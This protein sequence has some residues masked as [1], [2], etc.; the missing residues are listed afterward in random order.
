MTCP[1]E[2]G[3]N[4]P[5]TSVLASALGFCRSGFP[6]RCRH[7]L[8]FLSFG[9]RSCALAGPTCSVRLG[10]NS[11]VPSLVPLGCHWKRS[12]RFA[13]LRALCSP[14]RVAPSWEG[15]T[16]A[17]SDLDGCAPC[18][19]RQHAHFAGAHPW[20]RGVCSSSAAL[21]PSRRRHL[22]CVCVRVY[23]P[24]GGDGGAP[25]LRSATVPTSVLAA[26]FNP[27]ARAERPGNAETRWRRTGSCMLNSNSS[28]WRA[29]ER[30]LDRLLE[31]LARCEGF[32]AELEA[33]LASSARGE[34]AASL[35]S[36]QLREKWNE[37]V[38][39]LDD[40]AG[41]ALEQGCSRRVPGAMDVFHRASRSLEQMAALSE[42]YG[43]G[44]EEGASPPRKW[45]VAIA[46]SRSDIRL[47]DSSAG[48][49]GRGGAAALERC[50]ADSM[51]VL[52]NLIC[53]VTCG[54][55]EGLR[56]LTASAQ[57]A[58]ELG[59]SPRGRAA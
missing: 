45:S 10:A 46:P 56:T 34:L 2:D 43:I 4:N 5:H 31:A 35:G 48:S 17:P 3:G 30:Q 41:D 22:V 55:I 53:A 23:A 8:C 54:C 47:E 38:R 6:A 37:T 42:S 21:P 24:M 36:E 26:A 20:P 50:I 59:T 40:L 7:L 33:D 58:G 18:L 39:L 49:A 9:A 32:V 11:C 27:G 13:A 52:V 51:A 57:H 16:V 19:R 44:G 29:S 15:G 1:S 12:S 28:S 14:S 25:A